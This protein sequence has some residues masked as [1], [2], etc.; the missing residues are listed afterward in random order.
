MDL[1]LFALI[2]GILVPSPTTWSFIFKASF[3][4]LVGLTIIKEMRS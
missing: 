3:G 2:E 4:A 1:I